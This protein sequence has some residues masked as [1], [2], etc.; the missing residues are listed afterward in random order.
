[1]AKQ[2]NLGI[3][4]L[5]ALAMLFV[6]IL[7]LIGQGG[8]LEHAEPDSLKYWSSGLGMTGTRWLSASPW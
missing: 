1:M 3:D 4:L 8:L 7:H 5:R 2:R 6:I